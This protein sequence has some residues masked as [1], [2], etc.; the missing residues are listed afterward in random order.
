METVEIVVYMTVA[1]IVGMMLISFISDWDVTDT[2]VKIKNIMFKEDSVEFKEVDRI[3]FVTEMFKFWQEC[4][5]GTKDNTVRLYINDI[6][7]SPLNKSEVFD[8]I[9]KV[10]LC[11]SLS[12]LENNCGSREDL[13]MSS[14]HVPSVVKLTCNSSTRT[15]YVE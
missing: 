2:Y 13:N 6:D 4:G 7:D 8:H 12:S 9:E 11:D 15:L 10:N 5:L 3:G 1:I 14:L